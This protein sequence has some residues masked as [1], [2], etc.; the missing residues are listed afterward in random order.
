MINRLSGEV[1]VTLLARRVKCP[2]SRLYGHV[3][4][5][6]LLL[7]ESAICIRDLSS[8]ENATWKVAD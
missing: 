6:H 8:F 3:T 7:S 1:I 2:E 5:H 4:Y